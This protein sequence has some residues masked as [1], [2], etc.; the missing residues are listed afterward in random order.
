M[1]YCDSFTNFGFAQ[2]IIQKAKI[3]NNHYYSYF[4][5]NLAISL[6]FFA[7]IQIFS[8]DISNYFTEPALN[9]A[10][11][12]FS[13]MFLIT[14][15]NAGPI[16]KLKREL[17]F[18]QLAIIDGIKV[19]TSMGISLTL[20]LNGFGFWAIIDSML[21]AQ[22]IALI[23]TL[24]TS[25]F[26]LKLSFQIKYLRELFHFS[27]WSFLGG[28][29]KMIGDSIDRLMIGKMLG[30]TTLGFYDK[31]IGLALMPNEQISNRLSNVSFSSFSR[32]QENPKE[33]ENYFSK[34]IFINSFIMIPLFIGLASVAENFTLVLL[35]EK[36][37]PMILSLEILSISYLF[38][39][40]TNPIIAM[41]LA[42]EKVKQQTII[43]A[44]L[45]VLL[46]I[47]LYKAIPYGI[48]Y[49]ASVILVFNI[50]IFIGSY[51]LLKSYSVFTWQLLARYLTPACLGSAIM[52][53]SIYIVQN[54]I[55]FYKMWQLL[56]TSIVVGVLVYAICAFIFPFEQLRFIRRKINNTVLSLIKKFGLV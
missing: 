6:I 49:A 39:S 44:A 5:F 52:Y 20:A 16:V 24:I 13:V 35:G 27:I 36:W 22:I 56:L 46:I 38:V 21:A 7:A 32:L 54:Y 10:L 11:K 47:G 45:T 15:C 14:A 4:S 25:R 33:L 28:Q 9:D 29:I 50:L 2:A 17:K 23:L 53:S 34:I 41:N 31:S 18:K 3:E 26:K 48:E 51:L 42:V 40:L 8:T 19:I 55:P 1:F 30:T 12:V 43:R 37:A